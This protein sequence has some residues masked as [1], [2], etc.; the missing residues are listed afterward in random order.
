MWLYCIKMYSLFPYLQRF[1]W[2]CFWVHR[3]KTIFLGAGER[4]CSDSPFKIIVLLYVSE[5]HPR[6]SSAGG[7]ICL[8]NGA[9]GIVSK[10]AAGILETMGNFGPWLLQ[11][12]W[13]FLGN[14]SC[15]FY[16]PVFAQ[17]C[18]PILSINTFAYFTM[19]EIL[20]LKTLLFIKK[21]HFNPYKLNNVHIIC[22]S[23]NLAKIFQLHMRKYHLRSCLIYAYAQRMNKQLCTHLHSL[24][25]S[26]LHV[27]TW[28]F[29][30][31]SS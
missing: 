21:S 22:L 4:H 17:F 1:F 24:C 31:T 12:D 10:I 16:L 30:I 20:H 3:E 8:C 15:C 5:Q 28:E 13:G 2:T 19:I 27:N 7:L 6:E 11:R 26:Y 23:Q 9:W 14:L 18:Q 29:I 25:S